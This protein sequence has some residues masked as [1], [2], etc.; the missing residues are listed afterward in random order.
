MNQREAYIVMRVLLRLNEAATR[1]WQDGRRQDFVELC[2][3]IGKLEYLNYEGGS[4]G[5]IFEEC[6]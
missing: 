3:T 2:Y 5:G 1:A 4:I 6:A